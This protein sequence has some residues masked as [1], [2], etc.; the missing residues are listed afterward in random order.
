MREAS[1]SSPTFPKEKPFFG[2]RGRDG[3][4]W[5]PACE[6]GVDSAMSKAAGAEPNRVCAH[7]LVSFEKYIHTI[8]IDL[9]N[10]FLIRQAR[11]C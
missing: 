6:R 9:N 4:S 7:I 3:G 10:D 2:N 5:L 8:I 1:A 11:L